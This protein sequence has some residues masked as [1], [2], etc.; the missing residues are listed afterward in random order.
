MAACNIITLNQSACDNGFACLSPGTRRMIRLQLLCE[1]LASGGGGGG[2]G[3]VCGAYGGQ[4]TFTPATGCGVA[5]DTTDG[6]IYWYYS[7]AWHP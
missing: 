3:V 6:T 2:G 1:F 4:P 7:G 5:I